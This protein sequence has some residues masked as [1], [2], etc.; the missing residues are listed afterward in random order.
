MY[1]TLKKF[2]DTFGMVI[3]IYTVYR[4]IK[5]A[6]ELRQDMYSSLSPEDK[7][8]L[9]KYY[10]QL[11]VTMPSVSTPQAQTDVDKLKAGI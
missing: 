6:D 8:V 1:K 2:W 4:Q 11:P 9:D 7:A 3:G 10:S 5:M